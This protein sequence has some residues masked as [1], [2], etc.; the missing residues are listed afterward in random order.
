[1]RALFP[2]ALGVVSLPSCASKPIQI[3][4][5]QCWSVSVGDKVEGTAVLSAHKPKDGCIECGAS[6]AGRDCPGVAFAIATSAA[7][8][9]YDRIVRTTPGDSNGY[10]QQVVFLSGKVVPNGATGRPM[11]RA[12]QLGLAH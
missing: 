4:A 10:I 8:Q 6:V 11:I 9:V 7:N 1:M 5:D 2:L 12:E 3:A